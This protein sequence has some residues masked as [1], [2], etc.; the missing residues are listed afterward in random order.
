MIRGGI[1][2]AVIV[3]LLS[4]G[5]MARADSAEN[6]TTTDGVNVTIGCWNPAVCG[7]P[8][9][10]WTELG[11]A[12]PAVE[13][14]AGYFSATGPALFDWKNDAPTWFGTS[15]GPIESATAVPEPSTMLF[16]SCGI[17]ALMF[18]KIIA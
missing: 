15:S 1:V 3:M 16:L 11:M 8:A 13:P 17:L 5:A 4:F 6:N 14:A 10:Y 9:A 2:T 12:T 18:K 7:D